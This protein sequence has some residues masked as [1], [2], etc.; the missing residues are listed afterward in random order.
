MFVVDRAIPIVMVSLIYLL[1]YF[2][3]FVWHYNIDGSQHPHQS[4][5]WRGGASFIA[6]PAIAAVPG[7]AAHSS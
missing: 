4:D 6:Y 5:D 7:T 3:G 2:K 1:T